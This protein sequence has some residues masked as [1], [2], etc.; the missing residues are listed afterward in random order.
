MPQPS[1]IHNVCESMYITAGMH[2]ALLFDLWL[3]SA[4]IHALMYTTFK[5]TISLYS[6]RPKLLKL[7]YCAMKAATDAVFLQ[8]ARGIGTNKQR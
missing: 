3:C 2:W 4:F 8:Y 6:K 7:A 5:L 1:S